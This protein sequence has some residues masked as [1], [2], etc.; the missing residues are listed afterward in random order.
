VTTIVCDIHEQRSGV[1][2]RLAQ[3]GVLV[4][5]ARLDAGDYLVS[6]AFGIERKTASDFVD[7]LLAERLPAQ[8][9]A[10]AAAREYAALLV[11]GD[12]HADRRLRAPI[13]ARLYHWLSMRPNLTLLLSS[14]ARHTG[15][16]L[17]LLA[18]AEQSERAVAAAEATASMPIRTARAPRDILTALPGVGPASADKLLARFG[19]VAAA[20]AAPQS[21]LQ[22]A[23]GP[24][25]GDV[26]Y[27]LAHRRPSAPRGESKAS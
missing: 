10:L 27:E 16:L 13:L 14:D 1:P 8:L 22:E 6:A 21:E 5:M 25:R 19:S 23:L 4:E 7:S 12:W 3:Q 2:A 18:E 11:E 26:A 24:R 17:R 20:M 15:S 9:E